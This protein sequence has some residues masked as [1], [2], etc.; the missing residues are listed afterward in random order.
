M[1]GVRYYIYRWPD[2][3]LPKV[4]LNVHLKYLSGS[5]NHTAAASP[6]IASPLIAS[7]VI[8]HR[9]PDKMETSIW[10]RIEESN[11]VP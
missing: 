7:L 5:L 4:F 2:R 6:L 11:L 1:V 3:N 8:V 9:T 10:W